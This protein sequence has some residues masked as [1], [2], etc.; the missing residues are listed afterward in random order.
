M[1]QE[2]EG[3]LDGQGLRIAIIAAQFNE[4][5]TSLLVDG[6]KAALGEHGVH[7]E[8]TMILKVPGAFELPLAAD[9]IA[10]TG[11]WDAVVCV[12]AII[13]GE[14]AHFDHISRTA[15]DG[16][17]Q[18]SRET[19]VPVLLGILTTYNVEQAL[20]RAGG[21]VGNNG[22]NVTESAIRMAN[23]LKQLK[24]ANQRGVAIPPSAR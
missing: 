3:S 24:L 18:V 5:I 20:E 16:L 19:G 21:R 10:R 22:Y 7:D 17:S 23:L 6:A 11:Q 1:I 12:G 9:K 4:H 2:H 14:T 8:D 13:R 15:T